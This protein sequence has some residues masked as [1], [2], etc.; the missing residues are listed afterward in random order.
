MRAVAHQREQRE[1]PRP[2]REVVR[3]AA[4]EGCAVQPL[5]QAVEAIAGVVERVFPGQQ[6]A[7]LG[8]QDHDQPHRHPA[9][10]A[11][12]VCR[13]PVR[14]AVAEGFA[15][16]PDE[17]LDRLANPLA[18]DFRQFRLSL[19]GI[20]DRLQER[21]G[22]ALRL[23]NPQIGV[24]Q[25]AERRDLRREFAP[26]EPQVE[27][28]LAPRLVVEP[29]EEQP[30]LAAVRQQGE[31]L[32]AR[33]EPAEHA[34]RHPAAPPDPEA[35][36]LVEEHRQ[37]GAA[38]SGPQ[39]A[40]FDRFAGER[41]PAFERGDAAAARPA[42][43]RRPEAAHVFEDERHEAGEVAV[44]LQHGARAFPQLALGGSGEGSRREPGECVEPGGVQQQPAVGQ[45]VPAGQPLRA[46]LRLHV[47]F[48]AAARAG[49]PRPSPGTPGR[50]R[51]GRT[52]R[53]AVVR[54]CGCAL[55]P[56]APGSR[57]SAGVAG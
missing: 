23:G 17:D 44:S 7:R 1:H 40:R 15:V 57:R 5:E 11:V 52:A 3:E 10:G 29:G 47:R 26:V 53:A 12:D 27:V 21:R 49:A 33:A 37:A 48:R 8:E 46:L 19:A 56:A 9:G 4:A 31:W 38:R 2:G 43:A 50:R 28:P 32:A 16:P 6:P 41:L 45:P 42:A 39:V 51:P 55:R 34:A 14:A 24:Q 22:L 36:A 20:A 30:P 35:S 18:E 13:S 54:G 25:R